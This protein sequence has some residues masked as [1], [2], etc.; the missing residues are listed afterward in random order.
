MWRVGRVEL[1]GLLAEKQTQLLHAGSVSFIGCRETES[2]CVRSL[3]PS[4]SAGYNSSY[5]LWLALEH[6]LLGDDFQAQKG[7]RVGTKSQVKRNTKGLQKQVTNTCS[8]VPSRPGLRWLHQKAA[9]NIKAC[10]HW[11]EPETEAS[12]SDQ[13]GSH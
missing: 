8:L 3:F 11:G 2:P 9:T 5:N 7:A 13:A 1:L 10:S 6:R 4:P 12:V